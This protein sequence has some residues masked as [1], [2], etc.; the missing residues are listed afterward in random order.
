MNQP[1]HEYLHNK[2]A[3]ENKTFHFNGAT[4]Q[5]GYLVE[6]GILA[7]DEHLNKL[8]PLGSKVTLW[9]FIEKGENPDKKRLY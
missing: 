4:G 7:S 3:R 8:Y 1:L 2:E 6:P 9:D 5:K